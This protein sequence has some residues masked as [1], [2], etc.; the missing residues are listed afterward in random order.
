MEIVINKKKY[1]VGILLILV[2]VLLSTF[3][4]LNSYILKERWTSNLFQKYSSLN[5]VCIVDNQ[6]LNAKVSC[7]MFI[8]SIEQENG[9]VCF[10]VSL[11]TSDGKLVDGKICEEE[12][13]VDWNP[14]VMISTKKVP[15]T[16]EFDYLGSLFPSRYLKHIKMVV[17]SDDKLQTIMD[18]VKKWDVNIGEIR[19]EENYKLEQKG[20]YLSNDLE[21][22][23][24]SKLGRVILFDGKITNVSTQDSKVELDILFNIGN[25][26][27]SSTIRSKYV[28]YIGKF[29]PEGIESYSSSNISNID[30]DTSYQTIFYYIPSGSNISSEEITK[31]CSMPT[32]L[33]E[34]DA[35]CNVLP[36]TNLKDLE[37]QDIEEYI[38]SILED[39]N[40]S[41]VSFDKLLFGSLTRKI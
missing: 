25:R 39:S 20:Y 8:N 6:L 32:L 10:E 37:I 33:K 4:I 26:Q 17:I 40:G 34:Y 31:F 3:Y 29:S 12:N 15:V 23:D 19:T 9:T 2:V 28:P 41:Q 38:N 18:I 22:S 1:T 36:I 35:L 30:T 11:I 5:E 24:K 13:N 21:I 14:Q 7:N 16:I 27:I